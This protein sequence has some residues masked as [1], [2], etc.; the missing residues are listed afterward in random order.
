MTSPLKLSPTAKGL[1][2]LSIDIGVQRE[3]SGN[4]DP[5]DKFTDD[6][7]RCGHILTK[8]KGEE[9]VTVISPQMGYLSRMGREPLEA[10]SFF[11]NPFK[12]GLP[13]P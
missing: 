10:I 7:V 2:G 1:D 13:E 5:N 3:P 12:C 9:D 6:R 11:H 8:E 4:I